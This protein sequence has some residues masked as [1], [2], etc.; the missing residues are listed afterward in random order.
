MKER[1]SD[2]GLEQFIR[3]GADDLKAF[4]LSRP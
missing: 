2:V 1:S 3:Y 4:Y